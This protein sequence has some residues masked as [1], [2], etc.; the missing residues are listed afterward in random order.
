MIYKDVS[1][2]MSTTLLRLAHDLVIGHNHSLSTNL[3][4][5]QSSYR[6]IHLMGG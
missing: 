1:I 5:L 2:I 4:R 6:K 3:D